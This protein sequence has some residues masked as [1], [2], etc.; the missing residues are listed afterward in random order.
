MAQGIHVEQ[1]RAARMMYA[2]NGDSGT[3]TTQM[4][5]SRTRRGTICMARSS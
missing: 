5:S 1:L 4:A 3:S 2:F